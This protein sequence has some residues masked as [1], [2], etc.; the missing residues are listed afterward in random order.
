MVYTTI[1]LTS[2]MAISVMHLTKLGI[3]ITL[4]LYYP[5]TLMAKAMEHIHSQQNFSRV[6]ELGVAALAAVGIFI[7]WMLLLWQGVKICE[8][9]T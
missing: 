4:L 1:L 7:L 9:Q 2:G 3:Y 5:L 6:G 8:K